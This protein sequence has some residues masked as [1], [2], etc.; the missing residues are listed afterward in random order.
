MTLPNIL[1]ICTDQQRFDT[2]GCYGNPWVR[3]PHLDRLA[4]E[5][6][7]FASCYCQNPVCSPSRAGFLTGRYPRTTRLRQNGQ[8]IPKDEVLVTKLLADAGYTCGLAGKLHLAPCHPSACSDME[9]RI[10]DGYAVFHWSH[11]SGEGWPTN[12][13][14]LWLREQGQRFET[15]VHPECDQVR[16]GM[17]E[18][19]HQTTWCADRAIE[20]LESCGEQGHPWCFSV[21]IFDPHSAFDPPAKYLEP[22]LKHLDD[23]P[24]PNYSPGELNDK[25]IWQRIDHGGAYGGKAPGLAYDRLSPRDHRLIR[26]AYWAMCDLIDAQVGRMLAALE[27]S[28]QRENTIV[29]YQSDHGE[30]L[31]DHGIYLKGPCFYEPAVRVPLIVSAPGQITGGR[32]IEGLVEL[33]DIAP[34]LLDAVGLERYPGMQARSLWPMLMGQAPLDAH[35]EDAYSEFYNANF[36]YDPRPF[37]TMLRTANHKLTVAHGRGNGELYDLAAD[38]GE[39]CNLWSASAAQGIKCD[40]LLRLCDRM[41]FTV[42]PLPLRESPW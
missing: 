31:G 30:M 25:P 11:H 12:A 1:W 18:R 3:S 39:T 2:L 41:A 36:N 16:I 29:I 38:P 6:V 37:T 42:D 8:A 32:V 7:R 22:Y 34:T 21:N 33:I 9:R 26:A 5:G 35:R 40:L 13:Y 24:L 14:W 17:P 15:S 27:A 23:I 4:E 19:Y 10:D 28:G 20:F